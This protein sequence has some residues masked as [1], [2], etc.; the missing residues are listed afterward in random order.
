MKKIRLKNKQIDYPILIGS[1]LYKDIGTISKKYLEKN[2]VFVVS[3][4]IVY[5]L[6]KNKILNSF[7][8]SKIECIFIPITVSEKKKNINT[9][10]SLS[11]KIMA[12]G[13]DRKDTVIARGWYPWRYCWVYCKYNF[14]RYKLHTITYNSIG[15]SRLVCGWQDWSK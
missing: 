9:V 13:V 5:D 12:Y 15:T 4:S 3:D 14:T 1:N 2:R 7:K 6:Y 8:K 11:S 10:A